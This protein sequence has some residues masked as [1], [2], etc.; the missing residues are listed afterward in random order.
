MNDGGGGGDNN[1]DVDNPMEDITLTLLP[2]RVV[3]GTN[4]LDLK[5]VLRQ[6]HYRRS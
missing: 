4:T 6:L 1:D 5:H 2:C 3:E